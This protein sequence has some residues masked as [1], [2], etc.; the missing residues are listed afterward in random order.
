MLLLTPE[1]S[2]ILDS[3]EFD[4]VDACHLA[5]HRRWRHR[6]RSCYWAVG[7][8]V[9][10][11]GELARESRSV[12]AG[13][14]RRRL[15][16][17][18]ARA[19]ARRHAAAA[20]RAL[21][22]RTRSA[23]RRRLRRGRSRVRRCSAGRSPPGRSRSFASAIRAVHA[24]DMARRR[25]RLVRWGCVA[26]VGAARSLSRRSRLATE[27]RALTRPS[28]A[29][30][31]HTLRPPICAALSCPRTRAS[32][33][34]RRDALD[35][36]RERRLRLVEVR[37]DRA[38]RAGVLE[39]VAAG[40]AGGGEDRLPRCAGPA[41]AAS[42]SAP[43]VAAGS[44]APVARRRRPTTNPT[45][46]RRR[47]PERRRAHERGLGGADGSAAR[48]RSAPRSVWTMFQTKSTCADARS[49]RRT[50]A[51]PASSAS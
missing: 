51:R 20:A 48:R 35:D 40:A 18:A 14:P 41:A 7:G 4:G 36:E 44:A 43:V 38:G 49:S 31:A 50:A 12:P 28:A 6:R 34:C 29:G 45:A 10:D 15:R 27:L 47:A 3:S 37:P 30:D 33:P 1:A 22:A 17:G 8:L 42:S 9:D 16:A 25:P 26:F 13:A 46:H 24:L 32:R 23:R 21:R 11:G 5:L 39:R 2:T 19:L